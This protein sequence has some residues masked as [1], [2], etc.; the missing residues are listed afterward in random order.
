MPLRSPKMK[1]FIFGFQR[2]VWCPKWTPASSICRIVMTAMEDSFAV[3]SPA[4]G[5]GA[6]ASGGGCV[7]DDPPGGGPVEQCTGRCPRRSVRH[8]LISVRLAVGSSPIRPV[9]AAS[10]RRSPGTRSRGGGAGRRGGAVGRHQPRPLDQPP[11]QR[12]RVDVVV[13]APQPEV[14]PAV[15]DAARRPPGRDDVA[16]R[17]RAST[18]ARRTSPAGRR[19]RARPPRTGCR[20]RRR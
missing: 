4:A 13:A 8:R 2:R 3:D 7:I 11:E 1:R 18:P 19:R 9:A 16:G 14:Q 15:A 12:R 17:Q 20:R 10:G 5:A 6:T